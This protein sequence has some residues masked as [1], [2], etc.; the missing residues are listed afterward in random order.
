MRPILALLCLLALPARADE[1]AVAQYGNA[2]N[3]FP[4]AVALD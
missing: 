4:Y 1:I 2:V 3:A